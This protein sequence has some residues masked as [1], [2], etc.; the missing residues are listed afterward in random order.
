MPRRATAEASRTIDPPCCFCMIRTAA[1]TM[2]NDVVRL[3]E[4]VEA[5]SSS[6]V[7]WA[8]LRRMDPMQFATA[9]IRPCFCRT[10]VKTGSTSADLLAS[11]TMYL[12][13]VSSAVDFRRSSLRETR[14]TEP[15]A[16]DQMSG[17]NR[18][19]TACA[20]EEDGYHDVSWKKP[21][22]IRPPAGQRPS[23]RSCA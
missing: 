7:R 12:A 17:Q 8:G 15:P 23:C 1:L 11:A 2:W 13:P 14:T 20:A 21:D 4:M 9:S 3:V 10:S 5:H 22:R 19:Y 18:A 16:F 6:E